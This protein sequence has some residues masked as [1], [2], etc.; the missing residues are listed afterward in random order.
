[1]NDLWTTIFAVT[2]LAVILT[3]VAPL[4][5]AAIGGAFTQMGEILNIGL[6]GMMLVGA[7]S[8]VAVGAATGSPWIGLLAAMISSLILALLYAFASLI[9]KA[10]FIVVGIGINTLA[11]GITVLLLQLLYGNPG[12]TPGDVKS[13]LPKVDLGPLAEIPIIGPAINDQTVLV[14][15]AFIMVPIYSYVLYRT[16]YGVHLRAVGEDPAAAAVAGISVVRVRFISVLLSGVLCG[17][18][19]A[20]LAMASLG[21]FVSNMTAGRG[22]I[23]VAALTFGLAKPTRTLVA[24][25]IFGAADALA[26]RFGIA[27]VNSAL[28]LMTPYVLTVLALVFA[29]VRTHAALKARSRRAVRAAL[30]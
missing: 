15:F 24:C 18:A 30:T 6:E 12:V 3:K 4:L 10:D 7:F 8:A 20:Q 17:L 25:L 9:L 2:T 21:S 5:L 16:R 1:M 11:L 13:F 29:A 19:G 23:A 28:A 26:D 14:W 27:G 22:F